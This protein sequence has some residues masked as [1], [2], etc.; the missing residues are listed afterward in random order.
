MIG[1]V[2]GSLIVVAGRCV[3]LSDTYFI[4]PR[5]QDTLEKKQLYWRMNISPNLDIQHTDDNLLHP[6][7]ECFDFLLPMEGLVVRRAEMQLP[8]ER[9]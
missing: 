3:R 9:P 5:W 2:R 1:I 4:S 7:K 6:G 8:I